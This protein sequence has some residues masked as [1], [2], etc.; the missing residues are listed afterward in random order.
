MKHAFIMDPIEKIKPWKDTTYFLMKACAERGHEVCC[1]DQ[2]DLHTRHDQLF[3][4]VNWLQIHDDESNPY[5]IA[6]SQTIAISGVDA[7]WIRTDPPFDRR[8]F[9]TT[10]LL[11]LLPASVRV[12][13]C[14]E[15]LR[16][17]NEKLSALKFPDLTPRTLVTSSIDEIA[18]FAKQ[19]GRVTIKPI[20]G[21]GGKGIVF[22]GAGDSTDDLK[23]QIQDSHRWV[24]VQE[25]LPAATEG[26]KRILL[27]DGEP[28]GAI[29]RVHADGEEL[30]NM[31]AGGV[32][33]AAKLTSGDMDICRVL[34]E[35]L[36]SEGIF[37]A[38]IDIIGNKLIEI[39]VTSPT[40]LQ[41]MTRFDGI[42]YH[43]RIIQELESK[44]LC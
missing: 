6:H 39:N 2:R 27:L 32:A 15:G 40:G 20:D 12:I 35:P 22:F 5:F 41:E 11:E 3:G 19:R 28:L 33:H 44:A 43:H 1:L 13:N 31:D 7:V 26:D 36:K 18:E 29:L 30:N 25:Y 42:D 8:Y 4:C 34:K 14:P 24:I 21:F 10:L 37:F 9:Y 23:A 17:Y 38:G 16:N